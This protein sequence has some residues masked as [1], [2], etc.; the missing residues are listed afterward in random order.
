MVDIHTLITQNFEQNIHYLQQNHPKLFSKL[1]AYENAIEKGLYTQ[2]Y[3]LIYEKENFDVHELSTNTNLYS[4]QSKEYTKLATESVTLDSDN[5]CFRTLPLEDEALFS[6][7]EQE[8]IIKYPLKTLQ[9][10]IFFG[11]GLGLHINT[12]IEKFS[13]QSVLIIEDDLELFRL[14]LFT[15]NYKYLSKKCELYFS[16]FEETA[17]F[18][19]TSSTFLNS[20]HYYNTTLKF[21]T[22]LNHTTSKIQEFQLAISTQAHL[23]F[24]YK[25]FFL[26]LLQPL[27]NLTK[28]YKF[29]TRKSSFEQLRKPFI[30]LG[31][32]PSLEEEIIPLKES[33]DSFII[34]AVSATLAYL[35]SQNIHVDI[36]IHLDAFENAFAH[37]MKIKNKEY[38]SNS[39]V[40][41]S[42][43]T[44]HKVLNY[45]T[46]ENIYLFEDTISYKTDSLKPASPC[47]GSLA[48]QVLLL[49]KVPTIY[50]LGLD[51]SIDTHSGA[52]HSASHNYTKI[53]DINKKVEEVSPTSYKEYLLEIE[54]NQGGIT[55]TTPHFLY[56]I[57]T[58]NLSS[59]LLKKSTVYN[60]GNGAKFQDIQTKSFSEILLM[61]FTESVSIQGSLFTLEDKKNL[62]NHLS[63]FQKKF[64]KTEEKTSLEILIYIDKYFSKS[65]LLAK[66]P[67]AKFIN[68]YL[69]TVLP[70]LFDLVNRKEYAQIN[71]QE[72]QDMLL[73]NILQK[74]SLY[75]QEVNKSMK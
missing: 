17:E 41:C 6:A 33:Q 25:D 2:K 1:S 29:L 59:K 48:Y 66:Y 69:A 47:V 38:F 61:D 57:E 30:L 27:E 46:K 51:L 54:A 49:L 64:P 70:P 34:V 60:L 4:L 43:K 36:I 12:I 23:T 31:A 26:Q 65:E 14:S 19:P 40:F 3:E 39:I 15:T 7:I 75:T 32:G 9:K 22:M 50:L 8:K 74:T 44:P 53:L 55:L 42:A 20:Y 21:F 56:S 18:L 28:G 16:I 73:R 67:I 63:L 24:L 62:K 13:L 45:F 5:D 58:I 35:E 71:I 11:T 52:T 37:F 68:L 72:I 10:F